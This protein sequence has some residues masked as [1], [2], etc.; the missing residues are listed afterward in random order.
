MVDRFEDLVAFRKARALNSALYQATRANQFARDHGLSGQLQRASV[1]VMAN[2]A[3]GFERNRDREFHQH[4][5]V[6]KA[7]CAEVRSHL[8]AASMS[9]TSIR[10]ASRRCSLSAR[11]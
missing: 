7:S 4:L 3:E 2:I 11:K 1:S 5:S 9:D 6:A 10:P 8:Y